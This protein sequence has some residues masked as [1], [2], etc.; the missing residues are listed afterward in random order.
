[1]DKSE[2]SHRPKPSRVLSTR[3]ARQRSAGGNHQGVTKEQREFQQACAAWS[4]KLEVKLNALFNLMPQFGK[5]IHWAR[6]RY[7]GGTFVTDAD[8]YWINDRLKDETEIDRGKRLHIYAAAVD[9]MCKVCAGDEE[10]TPTCW[11]RTCPLRPVS[12]LPLRIYE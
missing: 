6:E 2:Q 8:L 11:D 3:A 7:Y 12:P 1:V 4:V 9:L 10:K 5:S